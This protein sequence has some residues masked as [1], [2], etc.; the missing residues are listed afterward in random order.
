MYLLE[1]NLHRH[2]H[3]L[4]KEARFRRPQ[5]GPGCALADQSCPD[6]QRQTLIPEEMPP[7]VLNLRY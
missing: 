3:H 7:S 5:C 1:H 2:R 6:L 4:P